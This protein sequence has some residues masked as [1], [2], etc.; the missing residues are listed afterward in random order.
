MRIRHHVAGIVPILSLD[1]Q[2]CMKWQEASCVL[3]FSNTRTSNMLF[4]DWAHMHF[5]ISVNMQVNL[6]RRTWVS[7]VHLWNHLGPLLKASDIFIRFGNVNEISDDSLLS[8]K[9]RHSNIT[10]QNSFLVPLRMPHSHACHLSEVSIITEQYF[11]VTNTKYMIRTF[12]FSSGGVNTQ[13]CVREAT[14]PIPTE[15]PND[16]VHR[17]GN[18][19]H[20]LCTGRITFPQ[21]VRARI[22]WTIV[23]LSLGGVALVQETNEAHASC[24]GHWRAFVVFFDPTGESRNQIQGIGF[25]PFSFFWMSSIASPPLPTWMDA[26]GMADEQKGSARRWLCVLRGTASPL[27]GNLM[28]KDSCLLPRPRKTAMER[29]LRKLSI[30]EIDE[31]IKE[32]QKN[33]YLLLNV[34]IP[35]SAMLTINTLPTT[36]M[37]GGLR[38]WGTREWNLA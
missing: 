5:G 8:T 33:L 29:R 34:H 25:A 2:E 37:E 21:N 27:F 12:D 19:F 24:R 31:K 6:H 16:R 32:V 9:A 7:Y 38:Q 22:S 13:V 10:I 11:C 26:N 1:T 30:A 4:P 14:F 15:V 28:L 36:V 18:T 3:N 17:L 35:R 23:W 20:Y